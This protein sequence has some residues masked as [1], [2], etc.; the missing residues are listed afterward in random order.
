VKLTVRPARLL[1]G[2]LLG[3]GVG[4]GST[5]AQAAYYTVVDEFGQSRYRGEENISNV[6]IKGRT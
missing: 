1:M 4:L 5:P 2:I 6:K 3:V